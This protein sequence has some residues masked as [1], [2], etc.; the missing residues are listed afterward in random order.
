MISFNDFSSP[1]TI[2]AFKN[3]NL[4]YIQQFDSFDLSRIIIQFSFNS[5]SFWSFSFSCSKF[6]KKRSLFSRFKFFRKRLERVSFYFTIFSID[7]YF[8]KRDCK[9]T[10]NV[11]NKQN[12]SSQHLTFEKIKNRNQSSRTLRSIDTKM[13]KHVRFKKIKIRSIYAFIV[14]EDK[15]FK[16]FNIWLQNLFE[17]SSILINISVVDPSTEHLN[18]FYNTSLND[19]FYLSSIDNQ[20]VQQNENKK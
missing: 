1:S 4:F 20:C 13:I 12:S 18:D 3:F 10:F 17:L 15:I 6:F 14:D 11:T 8:A 2:V 9:C 5:T 19:F 7:Q 16:K